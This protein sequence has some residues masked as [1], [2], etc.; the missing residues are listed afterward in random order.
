MKSTMRIAIDCR[1]IGS[2]G[3][4]TFIENV[5]E[6]IV[7]NTH[8]SFVL[9]GDTDKLDKYAN[10][11][12]CSIVKCAYNS[13]SSNEL[14]RF[15]SDAVNRCDAFYTPNFNI[16]LGI[17]VPVFSTIH[18][19]VFFDIKGFTAKPKLFI[20]KRY[21]NRAL[22]ISKT[23]FTVSNFSRQRILALFGNKCDIKVV[24]NGISKSLIDYK[25]SHNISG[26][27]NGIVFLGNLKKHKGIHVLM[28][29]YKKLIRSGYHRKLTI[30]GKFDFRTKDENIIRELQ[31]NKFDAEFINGADNETVYDIISQSEVLVSPSLYEG[32]GIP[33]LE[34]MYLDTPAI[35]SDIPVYR[36]V[37]KDFPV[38]F[39][40]SGNA[41]DLCTRLMHHSYHPCNADDLI[42]S[43]YNYE[44]TAKEILGNIEMS[45]L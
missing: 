11:P 3:I 40:H 39:F 22:S 2:S 5:L 36:E 18:D 28:E 42:S 34:A 10:L 6:Y 7:R 21:I 29:A 27:R 16:P 35:I 33:P 31:E 13:F 1:L 8:H 43:H 32:F 19:V 23:V 26:K 30:I 15:T 25:L 9:I 14:L 37:Y 41:E 44:K 20:Y 12:N 17:K 38:T 4:G 24:Y 45:I